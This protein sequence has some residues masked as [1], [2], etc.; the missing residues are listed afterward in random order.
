MTVNIYG[1]YGKILNKKPIFAKQHAQYGTKRDHLN[2]ELIHFHLK[3][4][5]IG[6]LYKI[7]LNYENKELKHSENWFLKHVEVFYI[8]QSYF[9]QCNKWIE[10]DS[11]NKKA[12]LELFENVSIFLF[13]SLFYKKISNFFLFI[14]EN[15]QKEENL[16]SNVASFD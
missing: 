3:N 9:F 8:D 10:T 16:D 12:K 6:N 1:D 4:I 2:D 14:I 11:N 13:K 5:D 7:E 15:R